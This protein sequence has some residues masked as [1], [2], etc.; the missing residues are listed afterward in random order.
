MSRLA[1]HWIPTASGRA[2][3]RLCPHHCRPKDS[4]M[5]YCGVRGAVDGTIHTFNYGRSLPATEEVI[6]T[7]A[8][9][10]YSPG[11]RILSM[12][13]VGCSLSCSFCQ[14]WETS[15][16]RHLND[17]LT[18]Q[19]TPE[20][21]VELCLNNNIPVLSWTYND[22]VVW[23]E[24]VIETS[25]LAQQA[26]IKTLYKSA[27][28]IE[29]EPVEELI[30]CIDIFS[31][32]L[33]S[34]SD[35]FYRKVTRSRLQPVLERIKQV[36]QSGRHLEISQLI[37]P[38]LN[39]NEHEIQQTVNWVSANL[40]T[41]VPLHFVAFHPAYQYTHVPRTGLRS[42][43]NARSIALSSGI[44]HVYLGNIQDGCTNDT[45]CQACGE[46]VVSR[47]GLHTSR[48]A[49]DE[50]GCC[51][52]CG[53]QSS[54]GHPLPSNE[55]ADPAAFAGI[56]GKKKSLTITWSEQLHSVHL[57]NANPSD[58]VDT[59]FIRALG[60]KKSREIK[61]ASAL[62]R[63]LITRSHKDESGVEISWNSASEYR[64]IDLLDR[65]HYPTGLDDS[66]S[67]Y[68]IMAVEDG[69]TP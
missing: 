48:V 28:F 19:Y 38:Q 17:K 55:E 4:R 47:Y 1:N 20:Q 12:G 50:Q 40:G 31:I 8:V 60:R 58:N 24:F 2:E 46:I 32:S 14:N 63:I 43:I 54:I 61:L 15:Q 39:D 9:F 35:E 44:N 30:E 41:D 69:T 56:P 6:E 67:T 68:Q 16:V 18:R 10:H 66:S 3:C 37:I 23:H 62:D 29:E 45:H 27:F 26:G 11:A 53:A 34:L 13:N 52:H 64:T 22:P 33:K 59:L 5:G 7:E 25:R 36:S 49:L 42:L 51:G 57:L 65:A 21:V